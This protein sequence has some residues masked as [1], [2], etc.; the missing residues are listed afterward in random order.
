M[1]SPMARAGVAVVGGGKWGIALAAAAA[2]IGGEV[3]LVTRREVEV[4]PRGVHL[5][6]DIAAAA[7]AE[8]IV[9]AVPSSAAL[10]VIAGLA[11]RIDADHMI[12]H[13]SRGLVGE[14]LD[15]FSE[16]VRAATPTEL[17][18]ALGGPALAADLL[19]GTPSIV[20]CGASSDEVG[21]TFIKRFMSP[22]LRVY[23]TSDV[24]GVE[25]ASA[26][27]GCL[28]MIVGYAQ[29]LGLSPGLIA[30][31]I[32]RGIQEASRIVAEAGGIGET[33]FG[34]AGYGELFA[35]VSQRDRPEILLGGSL[36]RG[37]PLEGAVALLK[38]RVEA[39]TLAPR[40][41]RWIEAR[42]VRAPIF[43]ALADDVLAGHPADQIIEKLM[44]LPVEDAG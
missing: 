20:V 39:A 6:A 4:A 5:T 10:G 23:T 15:T 26:L 13:A 3:R 1:P 21:Y 16:V 8:L 24:R 29:G 12:I 41:A 7:E 30:A 44:T 33:L 38:S 28:A 42:K 19:A 35:A 36:A 34:L 17:V 37:V 22:Q 40:L 11:P 18:G 9:L 32:T 2:R 25:W 31:L 43:V 14:K 27:V